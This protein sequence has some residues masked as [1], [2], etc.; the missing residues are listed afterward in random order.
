LRK[1]AW[2][3]FALVLSTS[4]LF[5]QS[6]DTI[7]VGPLQVR[8]EC[9]WPGTVTKGYQPVRITAISAGEQPE[10]LGLTL[11]AGYNNALRV[12]RTV[13]VGALETVTFE[14]LMPAYISNGRSFRLEASAGGEK[15]SSNTLGQTGS[16]SEYGH[17]VA[18]FATGPVEAGRGAKWSQALTPDPAKGSPTYWGARWRNLG[19]N[20]DTDWDAKATVNVAD[21]PFEAMSAD[22]RAYTSL[23][24]AVVDLEGGAPARAEL[25]ALLAW[26][27]TG[28]EVAFAAGSVN[29]ELAKLDALAPWLED[30]FLLEPSVGSPDVRRYQCGFGRIL[31]APTD[32]LLDDKGLAAGVLSEMRSRIRTEWTPSPRAS[33]GRGTGLS[34]AIPGLGT[35]PYRAFIVLMLLFGVL[36]WPVNFLLVRRSGQPVRL[37]LT[38]PAIALC[39]SLLALAYG[40]FW[41]GVDIKTQS[42]TVAVLDQRTGIAENAEARSVY[43]GLAPGRGLVP[44]AGTAVFPWGQVGDWNQGT[45]LRIDYRD[46]EERYGGDFLP[47][48][49]QIRQALIS[50]RATRL[51]VEFAADGQ[52]TNGLGVDLEDLIARAPDGGW[53]QLSGKLQ[54]GQ[55]GQLVEIA[56]P[57]AS[58]AELTPFNELRDWTL[59]RGTYSATTTL[60]ALRDPA[61]LELVDIAGYHSVLGVLA[62]D[63]AFPKASL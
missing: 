18:V 41:Q 34:P 59:P 5:A 9:A 50:N 47:S 12:Q 37:L 43:A 60:P 57:P 42:T 29:A 38:I 16:A 32:K 13:A 44:G 52:L 24:F 61:G 10:A 21:V 14:M 17:D 26:V 1:L 58:F 20:K 8:V 3:L 22:W 33:R 30:R 49:T 31:V 11:K 62:R 19:F 2:A 54:A 23:D 63:A 7:V 46:G 39:A 45:T 6:S 51:R 27:R 28:G 15:A 48:R 56:A 55:T 53:W 36:V 25:E 4:S 40:F 35:L